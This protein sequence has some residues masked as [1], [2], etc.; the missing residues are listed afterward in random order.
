[1]TLPTNNPE[2]YEYMNII[3]IFTTYLVIIIMNLVSQGQ[4]YEHVP[5]R[6]GHQIDFKWN[7]EGQIGYT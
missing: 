4:Y 1:M 7:E 6:R 2:Q 5:S 3:S